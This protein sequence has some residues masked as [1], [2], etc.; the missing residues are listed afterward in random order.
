[1]RSIAASD[2]TVAVAA[3]IME[4]HFQIRP[5]VKAALQTALEQEGSPLGRQ[6]LELLLQNAQMASAGVLPLCQ[7]T[8]LTILFVDIGQ[9]VAVEGSLEE[10]LQTGVRQA[11]VKSRLRHSVSADPL[12]RMNTGDNTPAVIHYQVVPGKAF[13]VQIMAK[14]GGCE[15]ASTQAML[16]PSAGEAGVADFVVNSV[17]LNAATACPPVIIGVGLGGSFDTAPLLAKKALL[18]T[19]GESAADPG[20]SKLEKEILARINRLG[21]GPQGWGGSITALSVAIEAA[22]CH[23]ASLPV[24]VNVDCHSHR[25]AEVKL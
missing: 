14:G 5:D 17:R 11:T 2:I 6:A 9:E 15:N 1:M 19:I 22:P 18:R 10:A 8:G 16:L 24:A 3:A 13:R 4:M 20:L 12:K 7:D 23:I 25:V 21:I